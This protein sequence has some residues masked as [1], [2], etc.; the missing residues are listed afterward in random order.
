MPLY[1]LMED[2]AT[3]EISR[4]QVWQWQHH[5]AKLPDGR[6]V[7][8]AL[9]RDTVE[10]ELGRTAQMVGEDRFEAG[11]YQDAARLFLDLALA[12]QF[13]R[14]P[15]PA[16]LR[17]GGYGGRGGDADGQ[18]RIAKRERAS[19]LAPSSPDTLAVVRGLAPHRCN[20]DHRERAR[21]ARGAAR[22]RPRVYY[23][24]TTRSSPGISAPPTC[25]L[26]AYANTALALATCG[27]GANAPI[28]HR[29]R[30]EPPLALWYTGAAA[31]GWLI[32]NKL[33]R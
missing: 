29:A 21:R 1:N 27:Y 15:D 17:H 11:R 28:P 12:D 20:G 5:K 23:A 14:V 8:D 3:A 19:R 16:G 2:A 4:A 33:Q 7:D 26:A 32:I 25:P 30:V 10:Q 13:D 18:L 6:P 31:A 24:S 22:P 9:I